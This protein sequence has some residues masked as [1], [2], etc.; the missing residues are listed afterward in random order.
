MRVWFGGS[1]HA[2]ILSMLAQ[3]LGW[4][5]SGRLSGWAS[6]TLSHQCPTNVNLTFQGCFLVEAYLQPQHYL[7]RQY[8]ACTY[9]TYYN[10]IFLHS[11]SLTINGIS[12]YLTSINTKMFYLF[13]EDIRD[14]IESF[15]IKVLDDLLHS[16]VSDI[17][18][19]WIINIIIPGTTWATAF[20]IRYWRVSWSWK[21]RQAVICC[22]DF[23]FS[24]SLILLISDSYYNI[25]K[26][27]IFVVTGKT[28]P[29]DAHH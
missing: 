15:L 13:F 17:W 2:C 10:D 8:S 12:Y 3:A 1:S 29:E 11:S 24:I 6:A 19:L 5:P 28:R 27:K 4:A 7:N 18:H 23:F 9:T 20:I 14:C 26:Y 21:T 22:K 16:P 25:K